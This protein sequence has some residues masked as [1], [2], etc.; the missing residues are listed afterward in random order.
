MA[1]IVP[2]SERTA[3]VTPPWAS[4][5]Q[6]LGRVGDTAF[7]MQV[8]LCQEGQVMLQNPGLERA[9]LRSGFLPEKRP[10]TFFSTETPDTMRGVGSHDMS[11]REAWTA[12]RACDTACWC[13]DSL[14]SG[15]AP[16]HSGTVLYGIVLLANPKTL[17]KACSGTTREV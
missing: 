4:W 17:A 11:G 10:C 14:I 5:N 1:L 15:S 16:R 9:T 7:P 12:L 13:E 2:N 3:L 6:M 8:F